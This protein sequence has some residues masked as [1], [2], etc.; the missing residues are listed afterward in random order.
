M[1]AVS[2]DVGA[3]FDMSVD[4]PNALTPRPAA[5]CSGAGES[6]CWGMMSQPWSI[7]ALAA[8]PSLGGSYQELISTNF[9]RAVG[10]TDRIPSMK[11]LMPCT[12]SG[13]GTDPTYPA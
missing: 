3:N 4:W 2:S 8:S 7:S 10:L 9:I 13:T 11:A 6:V 1:L 5:A 12:T